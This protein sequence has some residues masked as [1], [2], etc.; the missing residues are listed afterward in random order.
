MKKVMLLSN[1]I[2][3][4]NKVKQTC[5]NVL[6]YDDFMTIFEQL[7]F[8]N[9]EMIIFDLKLVSP[10]F[11]FMLESL[12]KRQEENYIKL[13][14]I[15][16]SPVKESMADFAFKFDSIESFNAASFH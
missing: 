7:N 14:A 2:A 4:V 10:E 15:G 5:P 9:P 12:P 1:D 6:A 16:N 8:H 11:Q 13:V 3:I